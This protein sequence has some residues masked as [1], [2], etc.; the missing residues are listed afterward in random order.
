M[1]EESLI[2]E[3]TSGAM[4]NGYDTSSSP[5]S[6][7]PSAQA[8][9]QNGPLRFEDESANTAQ[10]LLESHGVSPQHFHQVRVATAVHT[11]PK[12]AEKI[13]LL[14]RLLRQA[15]LIDS[16]EPYG[17]GKFWLEAEIE[18][19]ELQSP[20]LEAEKVLADTLVKQ[21]VSQ[22]SK[23]PAASWAGSILR[24]ERRNRG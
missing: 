14:A 19:R 21:A 3:R 15:A 10:A 9:A 20:H 23:A 13:S 8:A 7:M 16:R 5:A 1:R 4:R 6:C 24:V 2:A 12:I 11:S 22:P 18:Q 17:D